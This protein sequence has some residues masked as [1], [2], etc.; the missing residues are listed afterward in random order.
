[1]CQGFTKA[2]KP[3]KNK[4]KEPFCKL[5]QPVITASTLPT[6]AT[7]ILDLSHCSKKIQNKIMSKFKKGPS[8]TDGEGYIYVY[9]LDESDKYYKIGRT[10]RTVDKRLK[11]WK[12]SILQ[13]CWKVK[14]QKMAEAVLH[15]YLDHVRVY[16]YK[17]DDNKICTVWKSSGEPVTKED[18]KLKNEHKLEARTKMIEWF[19]MPWKDLEKLILPIITL[20]IF[21]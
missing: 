7:N 20:N 16:R 10:S 18:V 8:K 5:H 15:A 21:I 17:L 14:Y 2:G 13:V 1:M 3:C 9:K 11:E 6:I 12:G 4:H 19:K